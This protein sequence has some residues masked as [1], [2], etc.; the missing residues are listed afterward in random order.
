MVSSVNGGSGSET[1]YKRRRVDR[2]SPLTEVLTPAQQRHTARHRKQKLMS[3]LS[4][5]GFEEDLG[6]S[7]VSSPIRTNAP[8]LPLDVVTDVSVLEVP[9][10]Q[11]FCRR[12]LWII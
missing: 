11:L 6:S 3:K 5:S 12:R 9:A 1:V 4:D 7:P 2:A 10:G 8:P